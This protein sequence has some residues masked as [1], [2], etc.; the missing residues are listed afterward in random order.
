MSTPEQFSPPV[1]ACAAGAVLHVHAGNT[2]EPAVLLHTFLPP[3]AAE[4]LRQESARVDVHSDGPGSDTV[5]LRL[6]VDGTAL[7]WQLPITPFVAAL[8]GQSG[9]DGRMVL[10]G[11]VDAEPDPDSVTKG[12]DCEQLAAELQ[13]PVADLA[14]ALRGRLTTWLADDLEL[15]LHDDAHDRAVDRSPAQTLATAVLAGYRGEL[16]AETAASRVV[17]ALELAPEEYTTELG[18]RLCAALAAA[19]AATPA[20]ELAKVVEATG[21]FESEA[22]RQLHGLPT[23][24]AI[25]AATDDSPPHVTLDFLLAGPDRDEAIRA[26]VSLVA[27]LARAG[28]GAGL[29]DADVLRGLGM[30]DDLGLA[31][32][33]QL[34]VQ[35]AAG[36]TRDPG[37]DP[38]VTREIAERLLEEGA[39]ALRWIATVAARLTEAVT[40]GTAGRSGQGPARLHAPLQAVRLLLAADVPRV[41]VLATGLAGFLELA[42]YARAKRK[43]GPGS[44]VRLPASLVVAVV[45][46]QWADGLATEL[47]IDLLDELLDDDVQ[48]TDLLDALVCATAQ[49]LIEADLDDE[50]TLRSQVDAALAATPAG[51]RGARWLLVTCLREAHEHDPGASDLAAYLPNAGADPDRAAERLGTAGVL[52][53]G[54][55]VV[56][57]LA[58]TFGETARLPRPMSLGMFLSTALTEH[59]LLRPGTSGSA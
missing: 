8:P 47:V 39:P 41:E 4:A 18:G 25:A 13:L 52:A 21:P 10:L 29:A 35:L 23:A 36:A 2:L 50:P 15:L 51:P 55:A 49:L 6:L 31:R 30:V 27:R 54:L 44:W 37:G 20:S 12:A 26:A 38:L 24:L 33:A 48:A 1:Y 58:D 28:L 59:E 40:S 32:L 56:T 7:S 9:D 3:G 5:T 45:L 46:E 42:R 43:T 17:R 53:A 34:W 14:E 22:L 11:L 16:D 19:F 57:A